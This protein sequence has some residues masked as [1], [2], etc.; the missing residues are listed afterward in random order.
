M[1]YQQGITLSAADLVGAIAQLQGHARRLVAIFSAYD[2]LVTPAL[3]QRPLAIGTLDPC[4]TDPQAEWQKAGLFTP[5]TP[6]WNVTG[7]PAISLPLYQGADGL[8]LGV[9]VV[10]P[11]LGEGLLLAL[12]AQLEA[13]L[14]W[15]ARRPAGV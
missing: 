3:A 2:V 10:G 8:P 1:F 5:F 9:Q 7:Q 6:V 11:P 13:A 14:P 4:G 12:A 15:H